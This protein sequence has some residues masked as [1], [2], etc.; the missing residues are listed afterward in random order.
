MRAATSEKF[1]QRARRYTFPELVVSKTTGGD[2]NSLP[3]RQH[4]HA[5]MPNFGSWR[6]PSSHIF[7]YALSPVRTIVLSPSFAVTLALTSTAES[8]CRMATTKLPNDGAAANS[9]MRFRFVASVQVFHTSLLQRGRAWSL[10]RRL[11]PFMKKDEHQRQEE[12]SQSFARALRWW[13][14][15]LK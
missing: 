2:W 6:V 1:F 10:S 11:R 5:A 12:E 8:V 4:L 7:T 9:G 3:R 13:S 15:S 14:R